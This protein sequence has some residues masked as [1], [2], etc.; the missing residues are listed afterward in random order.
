M[1][2]T[3]LVLAILFTTGISACQAQISTRDPIHFGVNGSYEAMSLDDMIENSDAIIIGQVKIVYPSQ[4]TT[5]DGELP[6]GFTYKKVIQEGLAIITDYEFAV[7]QTLKGGSEQDAIRIRKG[8]GA[9]GQDSM[10]VNGD[11]PLEMDKTYLFFLSLDTKGATANIGPEH[12]WISGGDMQGLYR[13]VD[14]KAISGTGDEWG[15]DDLVAYIQSKLQ[16]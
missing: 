4:W 7:E 10:T 11:V 2:K 3:L 15:L 9:V 6:S 5:S 16:K 14:E 8:G 13:I 12:Y 1:K